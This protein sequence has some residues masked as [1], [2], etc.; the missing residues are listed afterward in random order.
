MKEV[1]RYPSGNTTLVIDR[2]ML[3]IKHH[4]RVSWK[5][6]VNT[7]DDVLYVEDNEYESFTIMQK[8]YPEL[9]K[10]NQSKTPPTL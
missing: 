7:F 9:W 4:Y 1:Y 6:D 5:C 8:D 2:Y 10:C 3:L